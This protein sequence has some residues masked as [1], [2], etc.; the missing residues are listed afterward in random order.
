MQIWLINTS[1]LITN[2]IVSKKKI[3]QQIHSY[4]KSASYNSLSLR[5]SWYTTLCK[6][7]KSRSDIRQLMNEEKIT[8]I[9]HNEVNIQI[10]KW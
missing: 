5:K 10:I 1:H 7:R 3:K 8:Q 9:K 6:T 4:V 2:K